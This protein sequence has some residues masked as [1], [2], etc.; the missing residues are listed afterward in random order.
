M[1]SRAEPAARLKRNRHELEFLPALVASA[2]ADHGVV[3]LRQFQDEV[4]GAGELGG[5]DDP[6]HR[7]AGIGQ[8]Y[9]V[10]DRAVE[11]DVLLKHHAD[12]PA[13]PRRI[14][15]GQIGAVDQDAAGLRHVEPLEQLRQ[16]A[17]A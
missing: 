17:L 1:S 14:D 16:R 2:L 8:G 4:V 3:A 6:L 12:L 5:L 10:A 11:Q 7:H 15:Q 13:Q 9:V